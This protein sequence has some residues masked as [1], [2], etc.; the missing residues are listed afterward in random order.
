MVLII[1]KKITLKT[2]LFNQAKP[3]LH[4]LGNL[5]F[6]LGFLHHVHGDTL[7]IWSAPQDVFLLDH[8]DG[9]VPKS[10][11]IIHLAGQVVEFLAIAAGIVLMAA[12]TTLMAPYRLK[13][14]VRSLDALKSFLRIVI[15]V[16]GVE[17]TEDFVQ[18]WPQPVI[19]IRRL[20]V[21]ERSE[22]CNIVVLLISKCIERPA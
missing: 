15:P 20:M 5:R 9:L 13:R 7:P 22:R 4:S 6:D 14:V 12:T 10:L 16:I 8:V 19:G 1:S 21:D 18:R 11:D 17:L 2:K 3:S